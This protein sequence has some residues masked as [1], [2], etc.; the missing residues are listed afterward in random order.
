MFK[1]KY[2]SEARLSLQWHE[3]REEGELVA[4][5]SAN[6]Y[7]LRALRDDGFAFVFELVRPDG[8][9]EEG[10]AS[11]ISIAQLRAEEL[12]KI[13]RREETERNPFESG[14]VVELNGALARRFPKIAAILAPKRFR[15][16]AVGGLDAH[17]WL[18]WIRE[19][20]K[21][22]SGWT[23]VNDSDLTLVSRNGKAA[24]REGESW[25]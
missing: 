13:R 20:N 3:A 12:Y 19:M 9:I 1:D 7:E 18:V 23:A 4:L 25:E 17:G 2:R 22:N 10:R 11:S 15:V 24:S 21:P 5:A 8:Q 16:E 14:D 6:G